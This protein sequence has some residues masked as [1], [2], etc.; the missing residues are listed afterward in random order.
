[1][2]TVSKSSNRKSVK[3]TTK[4]TR[5]QSRNNADTLKPLLVSEL[6]KSDTYIER[7]LIDLSPLNYRK[8]YK[9]SELKELADSFAVYGILQ[10]IKVR[11]KEDGRY[12]VVFGEG[13]VRAADIAGLT[14]IPAQVHP[15]TDEEVREIQLLENL[16]RTDPHPLDESNAISQMQTA[17]KTIDEIALRL[18]KSRQFIFNR[19]RIA[20]LIEPLQNIFAADKMTIQDA[21]DIAGLSEASQQEFF[22]DYCRGW[23]SDDFKFQS[24]RNA[25][26]RYRYDLRQAPFD[27]KDKKLVS[28]AGAC[29]NCPFNTAVM[30]TLFP[31]F[32]KS[33]VCNNKACYKSKCLA[34]TENMITVALAEQKPDALLCRNGF[35]EPEQILI[36]SLEDTVNLPQYSVYDITLFSPPEQPDKEDYNGHWDNEEEE[37]EAFNE[38]GYQEALAEYEQDK[39]EYEAELKTGRY[40][41]GLLISGS[42]IKVLQFLPEKKKDS[43][44]AGRD[45]ITAKEV[46]EAIKAGTATPELIDQEIGRLNDRESRAKEL[47]RIKVQEKVHERFL[48]DQEKPEAAQSL[49]AADQ[50]AGRLLVYQSLNWQ[51]REKVNR[52]LLKIQEAYYRP[53]PEMLYTALS[54]LAEPEFVFLIRMAI[55]GNGDSKIP[56]NVTAYALYQIAE[57]SGTDVATIEQEQQQKANERALK[58]NARIKENEVRKEKLSM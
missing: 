23:E 48:A 38:E 55:A 36:D 11:P 39:A 14:Q 1:M 43:Y 37:Q 10:A 26:S 33:A 53:D 3:S 31:E 57:A 29:T 42:E 17:G 45:K 13:R 44:A 49:T 2:T 21:W 7:E 30:K 15:Y 52:D 47:D 5:S 51:I 34:H 54:K 6:L 25:V 41:K 8:V 16:H 27:T 19:L 35:S 9:P 46:Q 56:G 4:Q 22:D 18:G 20:K 50:V 24:A 32:A 12:E 40:L 58:L 28:G